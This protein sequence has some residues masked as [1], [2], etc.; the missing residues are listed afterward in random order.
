M[1]EHFSRLIRSFLGV[2]IMGLVFSLSVG[3]HLWALIANYNALIQG[4]E[5]IGF[6]QKPLADDPFYGWIFDALLLGDANQCHLYAGFLVFALAICFGVVS[7]FLFNMIMLIRDRR[8]YLSNR[9][10][11][12]AHQAMTVILHDNLPYFILFL[13]LLIP[14]AWW[15]V[16]LFSYRFLA[17]AM[18]IESPVEAVNNISRLGVM[19]QEA[20]DNLALAIGR[21]GGW[22]YLA[23]TLF[24]ALFLKF[25]YQRAKERLIV[26]EES[27]LALFFFDD[28][29]RTEGGG[30]PAGTAVTEGVT[31]PPVNV[32]TQEEPGARPVAGHQENTTVMPEEPGQEMPATHVNRDDEVEVIGGNGNIKR[33]DAVANPERYHIDENGRFWDRQYYEALHGSSAV[34]AEERSEA[35]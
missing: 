9:D 25:A 35:A 21:I 30:Q 1:R 28:A 33:S 15:D 12:S 16:S 22:G 6:D 26:F 34:P 4:F 10:E 11:V 13:I 31:A 5:L 24:T 20:P 19:L 14:L 18:N 29:G 27:F 3:I 2:I 23:A 8:V 7:Y 32:A 17:G